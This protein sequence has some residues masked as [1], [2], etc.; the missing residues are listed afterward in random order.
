M[1]GMQMLVGAIGFAAAPGI[2]DTQ[3]AAG[4][5]KQGIWIHCAACEEGILSCCWT[6]PLC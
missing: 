1:S 6:L 3:L 2:S 4:Q 5:G